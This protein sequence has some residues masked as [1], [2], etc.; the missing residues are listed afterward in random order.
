MP[1]I[2]ERTLNKWKTLVDRIDYY[3]STNKVTW[4]PSADEDAFVA[5][6]ANNQLSLHATNNAIDST[7]SDYI[8]KIYNKDGE[9]VDS[10]SDEDLGRDYYPKMR[11]LYLGITRKNNGSDDILDDI[12]GSLP[13]PN[14][15]PF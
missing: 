11:Q 3:T 14:E 5:R 9:V 2:T 13:D 4:K 15:L 7:A 12:L 10:F 1:P 6:V 8:V